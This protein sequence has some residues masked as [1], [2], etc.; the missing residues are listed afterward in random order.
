MLKH[1]VNFNINFKKLCNDKL[2]EDIKMK[3]WEI[4]KKIIFCDECD[5]PNWI[6][7]PYKK[8]YNHYDAHACNIEVDFTDTCCCEKKICLY[9]CKF[10]IVNCSII[11][12]DVHLLHQQTDQRWSP[13]ENKKYISCECWQCSYENY[14]KLYYINYE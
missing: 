6:I 8:H 14:I 7:N 12:E 2:N 9:N 4:Y 13:I 3:I 11:L 1:F 5:K 10:N